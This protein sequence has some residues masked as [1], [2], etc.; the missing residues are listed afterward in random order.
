MSVLGEVIEGMTFRGV[1]TRVLV[2]LRDE[3][4]AELGRRDA[5]EH[6]VEAGEYCPHCRAEY[7][8]ARRAA[9]DGTP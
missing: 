5:C 9:G 7:H 8:R 2:L 4:A 3:I 1:P 6:G